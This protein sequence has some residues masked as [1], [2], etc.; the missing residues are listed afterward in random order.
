MK[1]VFVNKASLKLKHVIR[2]TIKQTLECENQNHKNLE[3]CVMFVDENEMKELNARTRN[4]DKVTD[5]LSFPAFD[6]KA[7]EKV[8]ENASETVHLGDMA[9]CLQRAGEQAKDFATSL[10]KEVSKLA[11]HSTLHL[12]GYDHIEDSDFQIMQPKEDA[13]AKILKIK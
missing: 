13:I 11:I 6:L 9:I 12:L 3:V 7:G 1:I 10:E 2:K 4:V 8:Q 5:V